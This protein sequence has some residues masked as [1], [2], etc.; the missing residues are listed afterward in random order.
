MA[1]SI[2][3]DEINAGISACVQP[4]YTL[5]YSSWVSLNV[6]KY[7]QIYYISSIEEH[8]IRCKYLICTFKRGIP[9]LVLPEIMS[10]N[11]SRK[12]TIILVTCYQLPN[13]F[14]HF[15]KLL[16]GSFRTCFC[17]KTVCFEI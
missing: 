10:G 8:V 13:S 7:Q 9:Q 3:S 17:E 16:Y 15:H 5:K 4:E 12:L 2:I 11:V 14:K 6:I 1:H